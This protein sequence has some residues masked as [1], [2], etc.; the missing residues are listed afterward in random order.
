MITFIQNITL[1]RNKH[2]E[3]ITAKKNQAGGS[4]ANQANTHND[5]KNS[6]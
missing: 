6:K 3:I 2:L 4:R 1:K 5:I